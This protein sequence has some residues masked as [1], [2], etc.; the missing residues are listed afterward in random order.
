[1]KKGKALE[2]RGDKRWRRNRKEG[3]ETGEERNAKEK[4]EQKKQ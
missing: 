1:M 4:T 2:T 3:K